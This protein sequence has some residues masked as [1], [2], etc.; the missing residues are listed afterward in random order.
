MLSHERQRDVVE[1]RVHGRV[2]ETSQ[3]GT[4]W[5]MPTTKQEYHNDEMASDTPLRW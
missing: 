1:V 4:I 5:T 3:R 2:S